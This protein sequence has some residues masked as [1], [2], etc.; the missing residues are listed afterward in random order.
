MAAECVRAETQK[1]KARRVARLG[2]A[3]DCGWPQAIILVA[4]LTRRPPDGFG[5]RR[6]EDADHT[7]RIGSH[8][9]HDVSHAVRFETPCVSPLRIVVPVDVEVPVLEV[10]L[11][12]DGFHKLISPGRINWICY[13]V[14]LTLYA[15]AYRH[16]CGLCPA[17]RGDAN[18]YRVSR[19]NKKPGAGRALCCVECDARFALR[20]RARPRPSRR[21]RVCMPR[22]TRM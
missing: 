12:N 5:V 11:D 15:C 22:S 8:V 17:R 4:E 2:S 1:Q 20:R 21:R 14:L 10:V 16:A 3:D 19:T 18:I 13:F 9:A 7:S 6:F